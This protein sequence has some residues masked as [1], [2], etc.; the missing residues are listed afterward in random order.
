LLRY[1]L[2]AGTY[3]RTYTRAIYGATSSILLRNGYI[4]S[5]GMPT[6]R[7]PSKYITLY[8]ARLTAAL[9]SYFCGLVVSIFL[10]KIYTLTV[11]I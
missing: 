7:E 1:K 3:I 6:I 2:A 9:S 5:R 4:N 10:P 11:Y 8:T